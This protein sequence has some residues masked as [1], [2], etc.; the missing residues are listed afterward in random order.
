[1]NTPKAQDLCPL[2][3]ASKAEQIATLEA[4]LHRASVMALQLSAM[5]EEPEELG[6]YNIL[7][8]FRARDWLHAKVE[9]SFAPLSHP[10]SVP[11]AQKEAKRL[12]KVFE[13]TTAAVS[14]TPIAYEAI[15]LSA[16]ERIRALHKA[17]TSLRKIVQA[18]E[19]EGI[20]GPHGGSW[21]V[22]SVRR[23][24]SAVA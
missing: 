6:G 10:D 23:A 17:G 3:H 1:M 16:H 4:L 9:Q 5:D 12:G 22:T 24:L 14:P 21:H 11:F 19:S 2:T 8:A 13:T 20:K 7:S 15:R 18:L